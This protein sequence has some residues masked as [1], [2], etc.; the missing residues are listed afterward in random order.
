MKNNNS[1]ITH[2]M[3]YI[4]FD[5]NQLSNMLEYCKKIQCSSLFGTVDKFFQEIIISEMDK[6]EEEIERITEEYNN[7]FSCLN[8]VIKHFERK[9]IIKEFTDSNKELKALSSIDSY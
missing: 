6:A 9:K 4:S 2:P 8:D 7:I 3:S 1:D 5:I